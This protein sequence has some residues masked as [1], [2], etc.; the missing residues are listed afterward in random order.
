MDQVFSFLN[1]NAGA[2]QIIFAF[3]VTMATVC[4]VT[5]T[6]MMLWEMRYTRRRLDQP[7]VQAIF[8]TPPSYAPL[9]KLTIKNSGNVSVH[10]LSIDIDPPNFPGLNREGTLNEL[11]LFKSPILVLCEKQEISTLLF[12]WFDIKDLP[13]ENATLTFKL[14]YKTPSGQQCRQTYSYDL[15]LYKKLPYL[16]VKGIKD[17]VKP[18]EDVARNLKTISS[19][20]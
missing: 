11:T 12:S 18:L 8:E 5:L 7:N 13:F 19:R 20:K 4:Y 2:I 14:S 3:V 16:I 6:A 17:I 10:D 15:T 9:T 1:N